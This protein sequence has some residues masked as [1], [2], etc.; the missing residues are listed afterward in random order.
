MRTKESVWLV[1]LILAVLLTICFKYIPYLPGDVSVTRLVQSLLPESKR[2]AQVMSST[3]EMPWVLGLIAITFIL[4][5]AIAGWRAGLLSIAS[6]VGLWL[7]GKW[8][9]PAIAQPRPSP[10][11]VHV[12]KELSGSAFPSIFAFNYISTVGFLA[13]LAAIKGRGKLRAVLL[14]ICV[15]LL[16]VGWIARIELAAHWPSDVTVSYL[17]GLLWVAPLMRF[18]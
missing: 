4:S 8:L 1:L 13:V 3:A 11:L 12:A 2:W 15:S 10:E 17:V 6:F 14:V 9:G 16:V 18:I 5:C 7:L